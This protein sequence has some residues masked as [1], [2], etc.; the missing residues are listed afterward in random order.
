MSNGPSG[1][2]DHP[3]G[4]ALDDLRAKSWVAAYVGANAFIP[5]IEQLAGAGVHIR[6]VALTETFATVPFLVGSHPNRIAFLQRRLATRLGAASGTRVVPAPIDGL[7]PIDEMSG[8][9]LRSGT[10]PDTSGS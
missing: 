3:D 9:T 10:I 7:L 4:L 1:T 5:A 8:G 6:P 2:Q